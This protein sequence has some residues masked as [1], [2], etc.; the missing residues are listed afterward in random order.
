MSFEVLLVCYDAGN[1][2]GVPRKRL[3]ELFD[4]YVKDGLDP[5][6]WDVE[7]GGIERCSIYLTPMPSDNDLIYVTTV[8]RPCGDP[9]L[10]QSLYLLMTEENVILVIPGHERLLIARESVTAHLPA[11]LIK[12][13]GKPM[14]VA[15]A[16]EILEC[17]QTA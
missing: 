2:S 1:P 12:S 17:I 5:D 14:V 9:R 7:Y 6:S 3:H 10:W 16:D 8:Y 11:D 15:D 4:A 13:Q